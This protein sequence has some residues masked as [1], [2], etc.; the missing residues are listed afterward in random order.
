MNRINP[1]E[2]IQSLSDFRAGVST[3]IQQVN[4]TKRPLVITQHGKGVAILADVNEFE[5]MQLR[6]ELLEDLYRADAQIDEGL[7]LSHDDAKVFVLK[8]LSL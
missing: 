4:D 5:A 1:T 3:F 7:G 8:G 6:L 2:D